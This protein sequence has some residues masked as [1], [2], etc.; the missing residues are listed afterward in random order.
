MFTSFSIKNFRGF[1][2]F[3]IES[4]DRVNL[5]TGANDVGKSALLEA[6]YLLI[7]ETNVSLVV[8]INA[9]RGLDKLQGEPDDISEWLWMPLFYKFDTHSTIK[10]EGRWDDVTRRNV[11][12]KLVPR[13][14]TQVPFGDQAVRIVRESTNGFSSQALQIEYAD[15][16]GES[17]ISQMVIDEKGIRVEPPPPSPSFPG[18]F[19]AAKGRVPPEEDARNFGD[20]LVAKEPY[21]LL[22]VLKI[23]EPRLTRLNTVL[24]AGGTLIY[25]DIGLGRMLP[26]ALMGDGLGRFTSLILK[27]ANAR[28]G[29]VLVDE[30]ENGLHHAVMDKVW[31]AI[32]K[33]AQSFD[34]QVF[35]T[36]HS[37]ECIRAAHKT[38][39]T[40]GTYDFRLHRL[41]R[42]NDEIRAVT[43]DQ[44]ALATAMATDLEVR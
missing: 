7:G 12:L 19:L 8:N 21:D 37:W 30:I 27:I 10:V 43:Y 25:G 5:I 42:I 17:R 6:T 36:T 34:V 1:R 3:T 26:L 28:H 15:D 33:A 9:F 35:A 20:L 4:L 38:F 16:S 40:S 29:V 14:S 31:A 32:A 11:G 22:D 18:Y 13:A 39:A 41:D 23:V 44:E 2:D 24:G